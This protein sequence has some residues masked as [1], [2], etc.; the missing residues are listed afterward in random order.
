[1]SKETGN[2]L[3]H[4]LFHKSIVREADSQIDIDNYL[5]VLQKVDEGM[6]VVIEDPVEKAIA[7]AFQLVMDEKYDPWE[8]DLMEFTRLYL[9]RIKAEDEVNFIVAGRIVLWA[10]SVLRL[11][12]DKVLSNADRSPGVEEFYF[13]GWDVSDLYQD[14]TDVDYSQRVLMSPEPLINEAVRSNSVRPVSLISLLEAFDEARN[15]IELKRH[16]QTH[17]DIQPEEE[18]FIPPDKLHSED[19]EEN[20]SITWQ[21]ICLHDDCGW[22]PITEIWNNDP[23]DRVKTFVSSLFLA[24]MQKI[25]MRQRSFPHGDIMLRNIEGVKP[26]IT[27]GADTKV[28]AD[29]VRKTDFIVDPALA[30]EEPAIEEAVPVEDLA[31]V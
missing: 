31:V 1:M 14:E 6:H 15:E 22:M 25:A 19:L 10:W 21:R 8:L 29:N 5:D 20:I 27:A 24:K 16:I 9:R 26:E 18:P 30:N 2:I 28:A 4:L 17:L 7:I 11:Q 3:N 13:D 23:E 12:S